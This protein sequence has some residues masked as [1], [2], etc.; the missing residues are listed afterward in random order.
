MRDYL[1]L[2]DNEQ[3]WGGPR[4]VDVM[5]TPSNHMGEFLSRGWLAVQEGWE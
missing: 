3:T 2:L 1:K 4:G 5:L